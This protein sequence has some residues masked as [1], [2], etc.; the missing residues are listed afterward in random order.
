[1]KKMLS[2]PW[3]KRARIENE[4]KK[5]TFKDKKISLVHRNENRIGIIQQDGSGNQAID[6][7][8]GLGLEGLPRSE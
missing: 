4:R 6:P 8:F 5:S 3:I 7:H 1:M 2:I